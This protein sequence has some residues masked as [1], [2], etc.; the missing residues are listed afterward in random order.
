MYPFQ[1]MLQGR[2]TASHLGQ[3]T[4]DGQDCVQITPMPAS[5]L[6]PLEL[7]FVNGALTMAAANGDKLYASYSGT[8]IYDNTDPTTG[9]L[10]KYKLSPGT[11]GFIIKGGTGRFVNATG[12]GVL[13]GTEIIAP[14][15]ATGTL[16][17]S[18]VISYPK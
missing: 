6:I 11:G 17:L 16:D 10:P 7:K 8:F 15:G 12:F 13:N 5:P 9:L 14:D 3:M 18:G 2:G 1:G 4:L